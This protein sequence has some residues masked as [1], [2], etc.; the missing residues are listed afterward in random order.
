MGFKT[1][2]SIGMKKVDGSLE[3]KYELT[4]E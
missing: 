1:A 2:L 3:V 4:K